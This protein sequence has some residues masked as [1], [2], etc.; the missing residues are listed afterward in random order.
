MA[1]DPRDPGFL[2]ERSERVRALARHLVGLPDGA[3]DVAQDAL[4]ASL[5]WTDPGDETLP[6][7]LAA[8]VRSLAGRRRRSTR[9]LVG[10]TP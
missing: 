2:L 1:I 10:R 8:Q 5:G 9:A 3:E 6:A 7:R 4:V